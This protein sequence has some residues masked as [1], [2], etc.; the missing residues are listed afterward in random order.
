MR[1]SI[2]SLMRQALGGHRG[3][4]ATWRDAAP[5]PVY[6]VIIIG[7]DALCNRSEPITMGRV[8]QLRGA[9]ASPERR[10]ALADF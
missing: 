10:M 5:K 2:F 8:E 6:D 3:W 9:T 1:Y 4:T 7:D